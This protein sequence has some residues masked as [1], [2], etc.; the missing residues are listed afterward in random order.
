M[1]YVIYCNIGSY[2]IPGGFLSHGGHPKS[3]KSLDQ[4][5]NLWWGYI[6]R[7]QGQ[8]GIKSILSCGVLRFQFSIHWTNTC[9]ICFTIIGIPAYRTLIGMAA[10]AVA[11]L[12]IFTSVGTESPGTV[13]HGQTKT[14]KNHR[15]F[16][17]GI[18]KTNGLVIGVWPG[19]QMEPW[20]NL[21]ANMAASGFSLHR[22]TMTTMKRRGKRNPKACPECFC[23]MQHICIYICHRHLWQRNVTHICDRQ[24]PVLTVS[25]D[26]PSVPQDR[27]LLPVERCHWSQISTR[28]QCRA[29]SNRGLANIRKKMVVSII[30]FPIV[31]F[32]K[33]QMMTWVV[34]PFK[35]PWYRNLLD[36][37]SCFHRLLLHC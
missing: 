23:S 28:P 32:A 15:A 9:C 1:K 12:V 8:Y 7:S 24:W 3:S 11:G 4:F 29:R 35:I 5:W 21:R 2:N 36:R 6:V 16:V 17:W 18:P 14:Y 13:K 31:L 26:P 37:I 22:T 33:K 20:P 10:S 27:P 25:S 30:M 34:L 19:P